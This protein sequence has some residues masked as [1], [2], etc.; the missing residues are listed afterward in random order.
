VEVGAAARK[1]REAARL[2]ALQRTPYPMVLARLKLLIERLQV[3]H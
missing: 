2:K 3:L 1:L